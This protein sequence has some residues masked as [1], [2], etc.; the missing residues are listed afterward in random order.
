MYGD[1]PCVVLDDT[2][3]DGVIVNCE[4]LATALPAGLMPIDPRSPPNAVNALPM[5]TD[6]A[7]PS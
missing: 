3:R 7:V 1:A 2:V 4:Y 6:L 5:A